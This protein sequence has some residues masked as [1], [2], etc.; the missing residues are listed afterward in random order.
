MESENGIK[1]SDLPFFINQKIEDYESI[2]SR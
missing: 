2:S 1:L